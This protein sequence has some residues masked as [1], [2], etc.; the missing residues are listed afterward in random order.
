MPFSFTVHAHK[1]GMRA[2]TILS[3]TE[4]D[5]V[6]CLQ[7]SSQ[8]TVSLFRVLQ[9]VP[10]S[11]RPFAE[12]YIIHQVTHCVTDRHCMHARSAASLLHCT[13]QRATAKAFVTK[14]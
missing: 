6:V 4:F 13:Q 7:K 2:C 12:V 3:Q 14:S 8:H 9:I 5:N 1:P 10:T 11:V